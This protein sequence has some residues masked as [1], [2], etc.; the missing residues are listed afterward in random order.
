MSN[1]PD[2]P[3]D[4]F[5][6]ETFSDVAHAAAELKAVLPNEA[7][8]LLRWDTLRLESGAFEQRDQR[9]RFCDLLFSAER[10]DGHADVLVYVLFEHLCGAPHKCSYAAPRVMRRSWRRWR[11]GRHRDGSTVMGSA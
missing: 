4:K 5:F 2:H 8:E 6:K 11:V 3:H 1:K 9:K 7:V 10:H